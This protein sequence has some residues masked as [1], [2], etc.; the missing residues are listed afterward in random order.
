[1]TQAS[2]DDILEFWFGELS[3]HDSFDKSKEAM[4]WNGGEELDVEVRARFGDR[5]DAA[6]KGELDAWADT[7]RGALGLIILLDQFTRNI[8]RGSGDAFAGDAKAQA[9]C[10]ALIDSGRDRDLRLIERAF[11]YMPLMHAEDATIAKRA[12]EVFAGLTEETEAADAGLPNFHPHAVKHADIILKFGRY[13][14]RNGLLGR[15]P[16]AEETAFLED[17]G[18][19]FGQH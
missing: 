1:M 18:P 16:T 4:W 3:A 5:V 15:E 8:G 7:A 19:T 17:G 14:H 10:G 12:L 2:I 6:L 13:P 9:I 11:A